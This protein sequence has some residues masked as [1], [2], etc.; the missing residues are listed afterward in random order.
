MYR[1]YFEAAIRFL[2]TKGIA[3][4][5]YEG[6]RLS[7]SELAELPQTI[8]TRIP[9]DLYAYLRELGDGFS[10]QWE[11]PNSSD[12]VCF[13]LSFLDDIQQEFAWLQNQLREIADNGRAEIAEEA[14]RRMNWLPVIGIGE[15]G[16]EFCLDTM[17]ES[18]AVHYYE[19]QWP[20]NQAVWQS[21]IGRSLKNLIR[22]WSRYCFSPPII[23]GVYISMTI[24]A[25]NLDRQFDWAPSRFNAQFDRGPQ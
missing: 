1:V 11:L 15:G 3:C 24:V 8:G 23:N 20:N 9:Q 21:S 14:K 10:I 13:G 4:E 18:A 19:S 6:R 17:T 5:L 12:L 16:Y 22:E 7:E 2:E 25:G